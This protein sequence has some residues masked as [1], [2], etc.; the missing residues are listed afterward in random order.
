MRSNCDIVTL[1]VWLHWLG[2]VLCTE[3]LLVGGCIRQLTHISLSHISVSLPLKINTKYPVVFLFLFFFTAA[4]VLIGLPLP[5]RVFLVCVL[6][7]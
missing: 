3:R 2:V 5:V 1:L 4:S 6:K 7:Y